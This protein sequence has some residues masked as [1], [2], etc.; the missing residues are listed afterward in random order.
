MNQNATFNNAKTAKEYT[1]IICDFKCSKQ[2]NYNTHLLTRKHQLQSHIKPIETSMKQFKCQKCEYQCNSRTSLWRHKKICTYT[3]EN[4]VITISNDQPTTTIVDKKEDMPDMKELII[5]L[6]TQ[7]QDMQKQMFEQQAQAQAQAQTQVQEQVHTLIQSHAETQHKQLLELLPHLG[8]TTNNTMS[9]SNNKTNNFNVNMF[10][11]EHCQNAMNIS[12]FIESLPITYQDLDNTRKHGLSESI[13]NMVIKGLDDMSIYERPIHCTDPSR[14]TV[15]VRDNDEWIKD[16]NN[17]IM[18]KSSVRLAIKQRNNVK[19]WKDEYM[20][21]KVSDTT[22]I[23]YHDM[24]INCLK[25]IEHD[26][27]IRN[28]IVKKICQ[29]THLTVDVKQKLMALH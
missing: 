11:N 25:F 10:L 7:N 13:S 20:V 21:G 29:A 6:M 12:D 2:S 19:V 3:N 24:V 9:N 5:A 8:N 23:N 27:K 4:T 28:K 15:Y 22:Q 26:E 16:E 17:E 14:K 1:C 18:Q